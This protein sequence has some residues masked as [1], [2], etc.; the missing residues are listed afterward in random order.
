[1]RFIVGKLLLR[2][3][4]LDSKPGLLFQQFRDTKAITTWKKAGCPVPP[5]GIVKRHTILSYAHQNHISNFVETG[6]FLGD[7]VA[8]ARKHFKSVISI[9][10]STK[11]TSAARRRFRRNANVRIIH[12]NSEDAIADIVAGASE[13]TLF[14]LDG[15]YSGGFTAR[16]NED[17]P[18]V[19]ELRAI[20]SDG[21]GN[22]HVIL[23]DDARHF[24]SDPAYPAIDLV[25]EMARRAGYC[26]FEVRDDIIR[27][28]R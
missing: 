19:H 1:M 3:I 20:F 15:H 18:V 9:E 5:P 28:A 2:N 4:L 7:T 17:T 12:A 10:L 8:F 24:G 23:I 25:R 21:S 16:A 11:L 26:S 13:S 22:N 27:I 14:F 6:T